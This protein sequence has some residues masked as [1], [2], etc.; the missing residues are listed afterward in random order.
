MSKYLK[1]FL[2]ILLFISSINIWYAWAS[3]FFDENEKIPYCQE[4]ENCSL[5]GWI[6]QVKPIKTFVTNKKFSEYSQDVVVYVLW[7]VYLIAIILII[8]AWF[9][10]LTWAWDEEKVKKS[11]KIIFFVVLWVVIIYL[12]NPIL[13]F[14][15]KILN[16]SN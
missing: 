10:I 6:E 3:D 4:G 13:V 8:Y 16:L 5:S 11:K 12:A 9:N 2:L 1:I 7:F 15:Q 14:V